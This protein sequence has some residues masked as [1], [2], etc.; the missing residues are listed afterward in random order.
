MEECNKKNEKMV[1]KNIFKNSNK[2]IKVN[3]H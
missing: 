1:R 2:K 3:I